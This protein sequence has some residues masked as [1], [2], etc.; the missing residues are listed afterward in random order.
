MTTATLPIK[1]AKCHEAQASPLFCPAC[2]RLSGPDEALDHF[3]SLG[4]ARTFDLEPETLRIAYLAA[5]R[6]VHPDR[7]PADVPRQDAM[8]IAARL[9]EAMRVLSDPVLRADYLLEL[10][11]GAAAELDKS[12]SPAVLAAT[13]E[14]RE[15][16]DE[17]LASDDTAAVGRIQ[18]EV[19][20]EHDQR[21]AAVVAL[22]RRLPGDESLRTELRAE[23]NALRYQQRLLEQLA[24]Q[25]ER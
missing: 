1:C 25:D 8:R 15:Q 7:L 23:L 19:R 18:H 13:L 22:A 14:W 9:N 2:H 11:G 10:S 12:V 21:A 4:L 17:A 5:S 24:G 3:S 6:S 20:H 16:I